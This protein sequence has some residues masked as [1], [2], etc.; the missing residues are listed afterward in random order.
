MTAERQ[1]PPENT[2]RVIAFAIAFFGAA[3]ALAWA[4]GVFDRLPED[5]LAA[6]AAFAAGFALLTYVADA[7]VRATVNAAIAA[8]RGGSARRDRTRGRPAHIR[9]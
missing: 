1:S 6:L 9:T 3:A 7:R 8:L 5:E 4:A 2:P